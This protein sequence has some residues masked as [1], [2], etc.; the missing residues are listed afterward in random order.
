MIALQLDIKFY[1]VAV[2]WNLNGN[3]SEMTLEVKTDGLYFTSALY[4]FSALS[5]YDFPAYF[6]QTFTFIRD[7]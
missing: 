5:S 2:K 6:K 1:T 7:K 3:L 4:L